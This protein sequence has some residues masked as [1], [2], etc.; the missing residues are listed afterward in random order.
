MVDYALNKSGQ[1]QLYYVGHSQGTTMGFAGFT[2]NK[3]LAGQ[4]RQFYAL[5]PVSKV[6]YIQ[7]LF[8]WIA[9][10]YKPITVGW[11]LSLGNVCYAVK[12]IQTCLHFI[13]WSSHV[14][15]KCSTK[16]IKDMFMRKRLGLDWG[17]NHGNEVAMVKVAMTQCCIYS[18]GMFGRGGR[19]GC[20]Q[21]KWW[22][23]VFPSIGKQN[24]W[25]DTFI[26]DF[27]RSRIKNQVWRQGL[28][29]ECADR[30]RVTLQLMF[31]N[32]ERRNRHCLSIF[33]P[34]WG[35]LNVCI[36]LPD[37]LI[38]CCIIWWI[39]RE[40]VFTNWRLNGRYFTT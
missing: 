33:V 17:P 5:A 28:P 13:P 16:I 7:G 6:E 26:D 23:E 35:E 9:D 2:E 12:R 27:L 8:K 15:Q 30:R 19:E 21:I 31:R 14:I 25:D 10:F 39:G 18:L 3:T 1:K 32:T 11:P 20:G 24:W 4:I 22:K 29:T 36:F 34:A 38:N 40:S 37:M